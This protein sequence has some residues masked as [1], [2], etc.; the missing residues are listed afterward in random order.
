MLFAGIAVAAL[1]VLRWR[2]PAAERPFRAWGYPLAPALFTLM[3]A[4][5]VVNQINREPGPA[6]AGLVVIGC[7]VPIY[8]LLRRRFRAG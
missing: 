1:F 3:S 4:V 7:G 2:E 5:M 6:A 8:F